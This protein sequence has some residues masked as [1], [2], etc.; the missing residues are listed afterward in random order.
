VGIGENLVTH[1][2]VGFN[3]PPE[4]SKPQKET[5][6]AGETF[7]DWRRSIGVFGGGAYTSDLLIHF[8]R[9]VICD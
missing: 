3:L 7:D 8:D 5:L 1:G 2:V 9:Q 4:L 6:I